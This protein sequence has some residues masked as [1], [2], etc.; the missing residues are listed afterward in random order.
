MAIDNTPPR[1]KL[2]VTIA[3]ITV[4]TLV[5]IDFALRSYYNH[6]TEIAQKEKL[7]PPKELAAHHAQEE[8]ALK[9]VSIEQAMSQIAKGSR[10]EIIAPKP[11]DDIT[12]MTGWSKM[13]K[14]APAAPAPDTRGGAQHGSHTT[15]PA[16]TAAATPD[17]APR[18]T[19]RGEK[20]ATP[21]AAP[22]KKPPTPPAAPERK[23][24]TPPA[25]GGAH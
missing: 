12:P 5:S 21:P 22:D 18:D 4:V 14:P 17:N 7:A 20:P 9:A 6:M 11:S 10:A 3:A 13:P 19:R 23:P 2:I 16:T 8:A 24:A 25:P 1:L 15:A